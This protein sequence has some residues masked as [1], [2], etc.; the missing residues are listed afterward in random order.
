MIKIYKDNLTINSYKMLNLVYIIIFLLVVVIYIH[1]NNYYKVNNEIDYVEIYEP[2]KT[3]YEKLCETKTPFAVLFEN[4]QHLEEAK[5]DLAPPSPLLYETK[6]NNVYVDPNTNT[7]PLY[8]DNAM[9]NIIFVRDDNIEVKM[10][11]PKTADYLGKMAMA[12]VWD[13]D[14]AENVK[15][16]KVEL[17]KNSILVIPPFWHYSFKV[18]KEKKDEKEE[19]D[20]KEEKN[21]DESNIILERCFYITYPNIIA[22]YC[23]MV[24][25]YIYEFL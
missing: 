10:F 8:C 19:K 20:K 24:R 15:H 18:T 16:L 22:N 14:F 13:I 3:D 21:Q 5:T 11:P 7:S 23:E 12:M 1:M 2:L 25:D 6:K 9:R 4:T 17:R